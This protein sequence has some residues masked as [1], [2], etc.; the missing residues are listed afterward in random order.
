MAGLP[1]SHDL[2]MGFI[3]NVQSVNMKAKKTMGTL[4][5][6]TN[7]MYPKK[8]TP[9]DAGLLSMQRLLNLA[10]L[11]K[12]T[13]A[14]SPEKPSERRDKNVRSRG[15]LKMVKFLGADY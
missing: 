8:L 10:Y 2:S 3:F 12:Y 9:T 15:L 7:R 11:K 1:S 6:L 4:I 14:L 13:C 5:F